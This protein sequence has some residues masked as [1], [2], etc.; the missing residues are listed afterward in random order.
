MSTVAVEP[1]ATTDAMM[2]R[3]NQYRMPN[4][5][6]GQSVMYWKSGN[7]KD[8]S[9]PCYGSV[10]RVGNNKV[11]LVVPGIGGKD[12]VRH[13][14]DP[15]LDQNEECRAEGCWDFPQDYITIQDEIKELRTQL[16]DLKRAV[17]RATTE[18]AKSQA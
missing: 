17:A 8:G 7:S 13:V 11:T 12:G 5:Y 15:R 6:V 18:K 2:E 4:V 1:K 9:R 3:I 10:Q 16:A 14:S